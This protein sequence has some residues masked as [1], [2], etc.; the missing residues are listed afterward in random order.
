MLKGWQDMVLE[1]GFA[2]GSK[3]T[4]LKGKEFFVVVSTGGPKE[5]YAENGTI[6]S[7]WTSCC[8]RSRSW[9]T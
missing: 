4:A 7:A 3:G 8:G 9:R 2:Y 5:A 6:G 1:Y